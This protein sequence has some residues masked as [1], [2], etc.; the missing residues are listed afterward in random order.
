MTDISIRVDDTVVRKA[1][2]SLQSQAPFALSVAINGVTNDA[3]T[4]IR[5]GYKQRFSLRRP[6]FILREGAKR[7]KAA[8]KRDPQ[9][10]LQVSE[11]AEFLT[12]FEDGER[13]T[14]KDGKALAVPLNVRRNKSNIIP[15]SQ[16]PPALYA[17]KSAAAGRVFSKAGLLLQRVGRGAKAVTRVLYVWKPSVRTPKLL[18]FHATAN[19]AVDKNWTK[20]AMEA[21]DRAISTARL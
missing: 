8:T 1:L 6:D 14:P 2:G 21:V 17:S 4:S 3:Q 13:K 12:R 11:R 7:T 20:R 15:A 19:T 5:E 18:Q 16:R 10:T 9:A